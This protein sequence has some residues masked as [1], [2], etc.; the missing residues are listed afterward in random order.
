[1]RS[2]ARCV[3][4]A[5]VVAGL[6]VVAG[7]SRGVEFELARKFQEAQEAFD[8]ASDPAGYLAVA[9]MYQE[10]LDRGIVSGAV[11]YNQGNAFM[12]AGVKGRAIA[13][14][15]RAQRYRPRD[16]HLQA[17]LDYALA[18]D[19]TAARR[20]PLVEYLLFWQD[21]ISYP[22]KFYLAAAAACLTFALGLAILIVRR[23]LLARLALGG[24]VVTL[25][26]LLSALY[27]WYRFDHLVHGV[28]VQKEVVARKGNAASYEPAFTEPIAEG[29]EF[30]LAERRGQWLLIRLAGDQEGWIEQDA[31]VVY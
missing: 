16:A 28:V 12:Q 6:P 17:N 3:I 29:T 24:V 8:R 4:L 30:R 20:R 2:T 23:R 15:R 9:A 13:C 31:A 7:C 21:W 26:L 19:G 27:D 11:Y 18:G 10:I 22:A 14:Y 25:L 1:M 5:A